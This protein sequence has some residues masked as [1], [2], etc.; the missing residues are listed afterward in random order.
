MAGRL[1]LLAESRICVSRALSF[2]ETE[3]WD[4]PRLLGITE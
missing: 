1:D 2:K 4:I 3:D